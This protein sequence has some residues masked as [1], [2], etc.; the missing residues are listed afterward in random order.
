MNHMSSR[1]AT[2]DSKLFLPV[3]REVRLSDK[4]AEQLLDGIVSGR[5]QPGDRLPSE[6]EL[7]QTFAV[8]R[9]VIREAVRSLVTRGLVVS[10]S[11]SRL[12]VTAMSAGAVSESMSLLVNSIG[13]LG[14]GKVH[15]VRTALEMTIAGLAAERATSE[16][17]SILRAAAE[18]LLQPDL[19]AVDASRHDVAFH[20]ELARATKNELFLVLL[21]SIGDVLLDVRLHALS[22]PAGI[23]YASDAHRLIFDKVLQH[24]VAGARQAM[25]A[26]LEGSRTLIDELEPGTGE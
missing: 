23:E 6:R 19:T 11:G 12:R 7:A 10:Q 26:H 16:D 18:A 22:R 20:R 13:S 15:E 1:L 5:L 2:G 3:D 4:V 14:Y 8:S 21:D 24:D 9:T 25:Q 17:M